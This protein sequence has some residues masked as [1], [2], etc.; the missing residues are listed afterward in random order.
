MYSVIINQL[1]RVRRKKRSFVSI[2][3]SYF[4]AL[5][6]KAVAAASAEAP[7]AAGVCG[8]RGGGQCL[9]NIRQ[10]APLV[11]RRRGLRPRDPLRR[12][13]RQVPLPGLPL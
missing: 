4:P 7:T 3:S 5:L 11:G 6:A 9:E 12:P 2:A 1:L 10:T 8:L 13:R